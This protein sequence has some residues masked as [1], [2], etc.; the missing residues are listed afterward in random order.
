MHALVRRPVAGLPAHPKLE[1][2]VVDFAR[3]PALPTVDDA[4]IALGTTIGV[5]GSQEAFRRVDFD[6][7][8][9]TARAARAAGARRVLD[10]RRRWVPMPARASST[11]A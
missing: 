11:T 8:V 7:V 5:A 10:R 2:H 3:L 6:A 4:Y 9:D 1:V